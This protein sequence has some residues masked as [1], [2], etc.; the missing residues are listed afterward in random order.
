MLCFS[1]KGSGKRPL[2]YAGWRWRHLITQATVHTGTHCGFMRCTG[3]QL[4]GY[5]PVLAAKN[6]ERKTG[7]ENGGE[8]LSV[9]PESLL[10][11]DPAGVP[12]AAQLRQWC[13]RARAGQ[14]PL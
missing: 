6:L 4:D 7:L 11:V 12:A 14:H 9:R 2:G 5:H 1:D 10:M 8:A 13:A 3:A